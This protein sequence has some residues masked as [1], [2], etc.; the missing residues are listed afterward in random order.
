[1]VEY[2]DVHSLPLARA[3]ESQLNVEQSST[4]RHWNSPKRYRTPKDKGEATMRR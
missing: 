1:M 2:K 4:G 3:L